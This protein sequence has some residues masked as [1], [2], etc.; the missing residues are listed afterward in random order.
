ME[1]GLVDD[2]NLA[3]GRRQ[4]I[5][6]AEVLDHL[7]AKILIESEPGVHEGLDI[8]RPNR[9]PIDVAEHSFRSK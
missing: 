7:P 8:P 2:L 3:G 9:G 6:R 1:Y 4:Q 5:D